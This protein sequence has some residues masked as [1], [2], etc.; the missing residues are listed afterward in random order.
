MARSV[1]DAGGRCCAHMPPRDA[2]GRDHALHGDAAAAHGVEAV[3][4][5]MG[6]DLAAYRMDGPAVGERSEG[7]PR[8]LLKTAS[9][10]P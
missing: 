7:L 6:V 4:T 8:Q 10:N 2:S 3:R 9:L 1:R 5:P